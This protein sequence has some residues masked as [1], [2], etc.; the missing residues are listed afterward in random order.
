MNGVYF[1]IKRYAIHDG[2]G[3][4]TSV[5]LKGCPMSCVWCHNPHG[6]SPSPSIRTLQNKCEDCG[7]CIRVCANDLAPD[8]CIGCNRCVSECAF[9]GRQMIGETT[10][11]EEL[12]SLVLRDKPFFEQSGGGVTFTGGEPLYQPEFLLDCLRLCKQS[13][14]HTTLDTSGIGS[15]RLLGD[16]ADFTDLILF[17]LKIME[18]RAHEKYTGVSN[19]SVLKNL[20]FLDSHHENIWIRVPVI[21]EITGTDAN[22]DAIGAFVSSLKNTRRLHLLPFHELGVFR[23]RDYLGQL[24]STPTAEQLKRARARLAGHGLD[25]HTM[26]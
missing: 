3:I 12:I 14:L 13:N 25:V 9:G 16:I 20:E 21:P 23:T 5:F 11:P 4:R 24:M 1:D 19:A 22:L 15:T 17:D 18:T 26:G 8:A 2:P 6:I 7:T 10:T